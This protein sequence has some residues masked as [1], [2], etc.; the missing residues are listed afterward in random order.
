ML[1]LNACR[2]GERAENLERALDHARRAGDAAEQS[3]IAGHIALAVYYGPTPV[4]D[5]IRRCEELLEEQPSDKSLEA[6]ITGSLA[7]LT[8][9]R[10]DFEE[11]RRLQQKARGLYER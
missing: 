6:A 11:G 4:A 3:T 2:W 10:G 7:G 1:P 8:A 5:A 9:M